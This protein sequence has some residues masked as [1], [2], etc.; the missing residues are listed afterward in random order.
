MDNGIVD[1]QGPRMDQDM[2]HGKNQG[3][4][5]RDHEP[6]IVCMSYGIFSQ[7]YQQAPGFFPPDPGAFDMGVKMNHGQN[8]ARLFIDIDHAEGPAQVF[9]FM[10]DLKQD[11]GPVFIQLRHIRQI[12]C[13]QGRGRGVN[14]PV[15]LFEYMGRIADIRAL[16]HADNGFMGLPAGNTEEFGIKISGLPHVLTWVQKVH[17]MTLH[18]REYNSVMNL[19]TESIMVSRSG[20][21]T[22]FGR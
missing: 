8:P 19:R 14:E 15:Q 20:G 5:K 7:S 9:R 2:N 10:P 11:Q 4:Y 1:P 17:K 18:Q 22:A 13:Q 3:P 12:Q 6:E 21:L 16:M